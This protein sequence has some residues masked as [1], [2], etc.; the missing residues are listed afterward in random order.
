MESYI[1]ND[2]CF[3]KRPTGPS[4]ETAGQQIQILTNYFPFLHT[5]LSGSVKSQ[6]NICFNKYAILIEPELPGD[7]VR[8]R[9][10]IWR[11]ARPE[12]SKSLSHTIFNNN[13]CYSKI[14]FTEQISVKVSVEESEYA[15]VVKWTNKVDE[16]SE[17]ALSLYKKFFGALVRKLDLVPVRR[18]FFQRDAAQKVENIE[19]WQGFSPTVN[20]TSI[21]ILLNI[22]VVHKVLRPDTAFE[23]LQRIAQ[24]IRNDGNYLA[25]EYAKAFGGA[26]VLTRYNN[27][28][29]YIVDHVA[30][31][32]SPSDTFASG[33]DGQQKTYLE[34]YKEKYSREIRNA[35]QPLFAV[36]DKRRN[37]FIYL[38]PELCY[39]T[40]L[41]DEMRS[42]FNLMKRLAEISSGNPEGK[43]KECKG[44]IRQFSINE[45]CK[46]DCENWDMKVSEEPISVLGYR[47]NAGRYLMKNGQRSFPTDDR[48]VDKNI[49]DEMYT[50]PKLHTWMV[51]YYNA[52]LFNLIILVLK[53]FYF[54]LSIYYSSS[55]E[56][57][58][59]NYLIDK[60]IKNKSFIYS[61]CILQTLFDLVLKKF[62][63]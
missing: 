50:Q 34:Y 6:Q 47:L 13:T 39:M 2:Y 4:N 43:L 24:G 54:N 45:R 62:N 23:A 48:E 18:N 51:I 35:R 1:P 17:E 53:I 55:I 32:K 37:D 46:K 63:A 12:I 36:K 57:N 19:V 58:L 49:Q 60:L 21:G 14:L 61:N 15:L 20:L 41:T 9:S 33:K 42:N 38:V 56:K 30:M 11:T 16:K 44:L 8:L 52:L 27:D 59:L 7:S 5:S 29:T 10:K 31:D 40:G 25:D 26:V 22:S 28:K 3:P